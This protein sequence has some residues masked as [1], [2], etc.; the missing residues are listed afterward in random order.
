M[1]SSLPLYVG[2]EEEWR[3]IRVLPSSAVSPILSACTFW[4]A[5]MPR[6]VGGRWGDGVEEG[7][8]SRFVSV[9]V[10]RKERRVRVYEELSLIVPYLKGFR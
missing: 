10:L 4:H 3:L 2:V 8:L 9:E 5:I 6:L 7:A 1:R